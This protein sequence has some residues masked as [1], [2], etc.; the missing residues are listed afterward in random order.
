MEKLC[1]L[2]VIFDITAADLLE[3]SLPLSKLGTALSPACPITL[4]K[5]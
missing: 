1:L 2:R 5:L 3:I 4:I